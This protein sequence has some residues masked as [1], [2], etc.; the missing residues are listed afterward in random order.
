MGGQ[1]VK[2]G[3]LKGG[4]ASGRGSC[5]CSLFFLEPALRTGLVQEV[6]HHLEAYKKTVN[7]VVFLVRAQQHE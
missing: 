5:D 1:S 6:E 4:W 2:N 7:F 3:R